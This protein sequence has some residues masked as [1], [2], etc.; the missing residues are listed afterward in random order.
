MTLLPGELVGQLEAEEQ[1]FCWARES[2]SWCLAEGSGPLV[3]ALVE[4][5]DEPVLCCL[6]HA[7]SY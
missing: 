6:G 7:V 2:W 3:E 5:L 4:V 1:S